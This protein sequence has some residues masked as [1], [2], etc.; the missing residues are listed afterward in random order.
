MLNKYNVWWVLFFKL[1]YC[2]INFKKLKKHDSK[3]HSESEWSSNGGK[4]LKPK[5]IQILNGSR[6][7]LVDQIEIWVS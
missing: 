2:I 6:N 7:F 4:H 3:A 5:T 1:N